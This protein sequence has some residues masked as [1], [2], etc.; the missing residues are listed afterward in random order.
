M[1]LTKEEWD[2][3]AERSAA[4][5]FGEDHAAWYTF[6]RY[7]LAPTAIGVGL[8][9]VAVGVHWLW[10]HLRVPTIGA[11]R[12]GLPALFWILLAALVVG[13][14]TAFRPREFTPAATMLVRAFVTGLL[15]LG[16]VTYGITVII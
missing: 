16:F 14:V 10:S 7:G 11:G 8:I 12:T 1:R 13:T 6:K 4:A 9:A 2:R 5:K 3:Q 15:W